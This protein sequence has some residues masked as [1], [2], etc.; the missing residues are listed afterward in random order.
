MHEPAGHR[1]RRFIGSSYVRLAAADPRPDDLRRQRRRADLRRATSRTCATSRATPGTCSS[2]PTS[3]T[4]P[5]CASLMR[6]H[7]IEAVV[8]FAAE[9]HVDRSIM[10]AEPFLHTNVVGTLR[11]LEAARARRRAALPA[12]VDRR[13]L[14]Q[15]GPDRRVR[16]D[17]AAR[18]AQPL[19]GQQGGG[20][21]LRD[22][23][24]PHARDGRGHHPL[25][26]QLRP[27]PVPREADPAHDPER[28]DGKPLPV[29]GDGL[30]V[31]DWIHVEDHCEAI[32]AACCERARRRGLQHRRRER[33]PQPG[34]RARDPAP[35]RARRVA[36]PL[37][38]R[39][40][41]PRPPLRDERAQDPRRRWAGGR[42]TTSSRGW[43]RR[44]PGTAPTAAWAD[45]VRSGAYRDYYDQQ[46]A[47]AP[48]ARR[49]RADDD[50]R[51][52]SCA[53]SCWRAA[54]GRACSR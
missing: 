46:Y 39:P 29:Y 8:N 36:D 4:A 53:A 14:R 23:V 33:A 6:E 3:A 38:P 40:P 43:R 16:G 41:R 48:G 12:G 27:V 13:G 54:P 2:A 21:P 47:R 52:T 35:D 44:W 17:D 20:R 19:L 50:E 5:R 37:R 24:P 1:R 26:E 30:Q 7:A 22:G 31:R 11:L 51:Q 18:A 42:A 28:F 15:P 9:S 32:D 45:R 25:L 10:S 49:R 34:R